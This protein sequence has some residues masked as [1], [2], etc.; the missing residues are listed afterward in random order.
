MTWMKL[1]LPANT[2]VTPEPLFRTH[3]NQFLVSTIKE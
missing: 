3:G 1:F 2:M